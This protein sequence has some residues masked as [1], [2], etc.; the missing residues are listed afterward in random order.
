[1]DINCPYCK[2]LFQVGNNEGGYNGIWACPFCEESVF[3]TCYGVQTQEKYCECI[4]RYVGL[5][6]IYD[7][8]IKWKKAVKEDSESD[9][10]VDAALILWDA[11]ENLEDSKNE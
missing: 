1:M 2:E 10:A 7:L 11:I 9:D 4:K 8:A 5:L 3:I 6:S